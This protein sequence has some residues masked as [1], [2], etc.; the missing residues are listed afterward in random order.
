MIY[1]YSSEPPVE[2]LEDPPFL[3]PVLMLKLQGFDNRCT[4]IKRHRAVVKP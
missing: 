3:L 2:Y 1:G 4:S